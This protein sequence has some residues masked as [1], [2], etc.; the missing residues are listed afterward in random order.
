MI[1]FKPLITLLI[2]ALFN[3][4]SSITNKT[5]IKKP[6]V[7]ILFVDDLG[8]GD[9]GCY[10]SPNKTPYIDQLASEGSKFNNFYVPVPVCSASRAALL[11]G[12]YPARIGIPGVLFH[13]DTIGINTQEYTLAEM[14]R[15]KNYKTA[16]IGKW[17]LGW[18]RSFLPLQHGFD[19]FFGLPYSNDMW[20]RSD[21][22]GSPV[23][24]NTYKSNLPE[25]A[26][27]KQNQAIEKITSIE[28]QGKL[29][30]RYTEEAL[31][32]ITKNKE[33]PF[34]LYL[35][36]SMPHI[37]L[38]VT[39]NFENKNQTLYTNVVNE[40][41][42]SVGQITKQ[43][44]KLKLTDDTIIIF[45]SDN[46]PWLNYGN[47]AGNTGGLR[48]GKGTCW[49]G[50]VKVP[51]IVKWPGKIPVNYEN[52]GLS[53]TLDILPSLTKIIN[54][55]LPDLPIDGIDLSESWLHKKINSKR[56]FIAYY[57]QKYK[58][59][60]V[61][62]DHWKLILPHT[63]GSYNTVVGNDGNNGKRIPVSIKT[64]E[65]YDLETDP[66][67]SLNI[68]DSN[69]EIVRLLMDFANQTRQQFGDELTQVKGSEVRPAGTHNS[70]R[71]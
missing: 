31:A 20:P 9:L 52:K 36:H 51:C 67:E 58:L 10:G 24:P 69:Q 15:D 62:K 5:L 12:C 26:L 53:S 35:A 2:A 70:L 21:I 44:E 41:D 13:K 11:T 49:E 45:T 40:I 60:A 47:H 38:G 14:F 63:Y 65:L 32:F 1:S 27:I 17:H 37:P 28:D 16:C 61:R 64:A 8:Y 4:S 55:K 7:I 6:N 22:D 29:T 39:L 3:A 48:E 19:Y 68:S 54:G 50:G 34:F 25:L 30:K 66:L 59:E 33:K 56:E 23:K 71:P 42:W 18:Q 43:L 46:G 57:N